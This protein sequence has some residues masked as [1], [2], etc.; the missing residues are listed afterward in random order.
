MQ[1]IIS[2]SLR[3]T[4]YIGTSAQCLSGIYRPVDNEMKM[5]NFEAQDM[6]Q[7]HAV[8]VNSIMFM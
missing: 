4:D 5:M 1:I 3:G 8:A 7:V 2:E 6:F